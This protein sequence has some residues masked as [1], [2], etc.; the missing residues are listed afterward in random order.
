[1]KT[2]IAKVVLAA[3]VA[4]AG[5][6]VANP[7]QAAIA[8]KFTPSITLADRGE[9]VKFSGATRK[10]AEV[11]I[12]FRK[13]GGDWVHRKTLKAS[14]TGTYSVSLAAWNTGEWQARVVGRANVT[15]FVQVGINP[16]GPHAAFPGLARNDSTGR[17]FAVW[18]E[19]VGGHMGNTAAIKFSTSEDSGVTWSYNTTIADASIDN[20]DGNIV[21]LDSGLLVVSYF[22][23][24]GSNV[25][26]TFVR[27][28]DNEGASWSSERR[29]APEGLVT[30]SPPVEAL[31]AVWVATY[32][33]PED[34]R[35][36]V[37]FRSQD[38]GSSWEAVSTPVTLDEMGGENFSEPN[39][40]YTGDELVM[41]VRSDEGT[42]QTARIS[43]E[44]GQNW[45]E[46]EREFQSNSRVS[47]TT[48][49][50]TLVALYRGQDAMNRLYKRTSIDGGESWS[51]PELLAQEGYRNVYAS[52]VDLGNGQVGYITSFEVSNKATNPLR[53]QTTAA[54]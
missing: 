33:G 49:G 36:A 20:R 34:N 24:P 23:R 21:P 3:A 18:R 43:S 11:K 50:D 25:L 32:G 54:N 12:Y 48:V 4:F 26:G 13:S 45:G 31:G 10:S 27:T 15:R 16:P 42:R 1:M 53:F 28:S 22:K 19:S 6:G 39:L 35:R 41:M 7:A 9:T 5:V 37:V 52:P 51:E 14:S 40:V 29:V 47:M 8:S 2:T 17:L 30:S 46:V 44:D 38:A